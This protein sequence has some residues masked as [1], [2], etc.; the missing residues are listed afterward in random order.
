MNLLVLKERIKELYQKYEYIISPILKFALALTVLLII[1]S[2]I[3]YDARLK[4]IS[5]VLVLSLLSAFTPGAV[6][7]LIGAI[8]AIAH[9]YFVSKILSVITIVIIF[10][11][12]FL[13]IRFTPKQ[14]YVVLILPI[15]FVLKIPYAVPILLGIIATP[16]SIIPVSCGV[17]MYFFFNMIQSA[18]AM[19]TNISV[20]NVLQLY[21]YV[22]DGLISN[23]QML[24]T[25]IV[26][27]VIIILTYIVRRLKVDY[28][29]NI[30]I[31]SGAA[32]N[33]LMF[34]IIDLQLDVSEKILSMI[35]GTIISAGIVFAI[36]FFR[37]N[38]DYSR[39]EHV[40]FEDDDYYYY[41]KAVPK[42]NVTT[43]EVNVKRIN[44]Q[45]ATEDVIGDRME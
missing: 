35:I 37:L 28:A 21:K 6:M 20:E 44:P 36:Q 29:F 19:P 1:N 11:L 31:I 43:P 45:K 27:S 25:V 8:V 16:I 40:Q 24:L 33:I 10:I 30:A 2:E 4:K 5:V 12:Y 15:L 3:G 23:K 22:M 32:G 42:I 17:V 26:F 39:V 13:L 38:L 41:V 34:L 7:V 9:V 18:A 14:C